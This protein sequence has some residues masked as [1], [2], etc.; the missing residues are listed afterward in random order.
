M[1]GMTWNS[2]M[3][4]NVESL[5]AQHRTLIALINELGDAMNNGKTDVVI[6]S[7][8]SKLIAYTQFH[9]DYEENCMVISCFAHLDHHKCEHDGLKKK[10]KSLEKD[11]LAG[12]AN[13]ADEIMST[14]QQWLHQHIME[15][16][17][18]YSPHFI[19]NGIQ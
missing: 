14:L 10:V 17:K 1:N 11:F 4:V 16:D 19:Q 9:F 3:S 6:G 12:K 13:I 15:S 5:D 7:V 2:A 18:Q 8:L